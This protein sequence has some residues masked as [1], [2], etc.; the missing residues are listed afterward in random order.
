MLIVELDGD[1]I[2]TWGGKANQHRP[3]DWGQQGGTPSTLASSQNKLWG[4]SSALETDVH[5]QE[6]GV[7]GDRAE[8]E[9]HPR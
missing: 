6:C 8:K 4:W 2:V 7:E 1:L 9:R 5:S 3:Q